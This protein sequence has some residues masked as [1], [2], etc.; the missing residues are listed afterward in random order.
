MISDQQKKIVGKLVEHMLPGSYSIF[1]QLNLSRFLDIEHTGELEE[2]MKGFDHLTERVLTTANSAWYTDEPAT[3]LTEC[4]L[5]LGSKDFFSSVLSAAMGEAMKDE[6]KSAPMWIH[7]DLCSRFSEFLSMRIDPG[8]TEDA[9]LIGCFHDM[10]VGLCQARLDNYSYFAREALLNDPDIPAFESKAYAINHCYLSAELARRWG[11]SEVVQ[12]VVAHHHDRNDANL[13]DHR[14][15]RLLCIHVLSEHLY[16]TS[17]SAFDPVLNE[18]P[19][20]I[21]DWCAPVLGVQKSV[22]KQT[23][24]D[25]LEIQSM[26]QS[27]TV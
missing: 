8:L 26:R 4:F 20:D 2:L 22:L 9:F 1:E 25:I 10:G 17:S 16:Q 11:F 14:Q 12:N 21:L 7:I 15:H 3:S 23:L 13:M 19:D 27:M 18:S 24:D 5:K 6:K